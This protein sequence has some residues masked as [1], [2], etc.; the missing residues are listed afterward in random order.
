MLAMICSMLLSVMG[1]ALKY[2]AS[3]APDKALAILL[4]VEPV[5]DQVV[6]AAKAEK[7]KRDA[8]A[9]KA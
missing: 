9:K 2:L 3:K 4:Q 5:L 7:A 1:P 6:A 8:E